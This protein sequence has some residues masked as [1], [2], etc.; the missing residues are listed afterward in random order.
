MKKNWLCREDSWSWRLLFPLSWLEVSWKLFAFT[1]TM[2]NGTH[3]PRFWKPTTN[4]K[5]FSLYCFALIANYKSSPSFFHYI[6]HWANP[7][8]KEDVKFDKTEIRDIN[9]LRLTFC[10]TKC[11]EDWLWILI[12]AFL[13]YTIKN[14]SWRYMCNLCH[15][16]FSCDLSS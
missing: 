10:L 16:A 9:C 11:A 4:Q 13:K 5:V 12:I 1:C 14:I 7:T 8:R 6:R 3:L 2:A 15:H